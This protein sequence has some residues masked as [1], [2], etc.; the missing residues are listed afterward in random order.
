MKQTHYW[1]RQYLPSKSKICML[2]DDLS[3]LRLI[4]VFFLPF[5]R[6]HPSSSKNG[7]L[8]ITIDSSESGRNLFGNN[9][10][11]WSKMV[12]ELYPPGTSTR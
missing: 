7:N 5:K 1:G 2:L 10:S 3:M 9:V 12:M 11:S 8:V 6:R 4:W